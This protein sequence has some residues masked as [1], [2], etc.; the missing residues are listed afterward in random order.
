MQSTI[1]QKEKV[2]STLFVVYFYVCFV[3]G[4]VIST[5]ILLL[6]TLMGISI[7]ADLTGLEKIRDYIDSTIEHCIDSIIAKIAR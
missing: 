3:V 7:I 6:L 4:F 2:M 5:I 1:K